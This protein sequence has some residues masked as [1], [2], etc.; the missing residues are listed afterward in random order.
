MPTSEASIVAACLSLIRG[1]GG[2]AVKIHGG[3]FGHAGNPDILGCLQGRALAVE[4]KRPGG[5]PTAAQL[6]Q[7]GKWSAAGALA[8]WVTSAAELADALTAEGLLS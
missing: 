5:K 6:A 7:L 3:A 8:L 4:V 2:H 1:A